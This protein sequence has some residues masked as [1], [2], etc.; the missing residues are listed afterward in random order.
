MEFITV[1]IF[2]YFQDK[3]FWY[4]HIKHDCKKYKANCDICCNYMCPRYQFLSKDK[5]KEFINNLKLKIR[6]FFLRN[7]EK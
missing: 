4:F 1:L 3:A 7:K 6:R 2:L 5:D